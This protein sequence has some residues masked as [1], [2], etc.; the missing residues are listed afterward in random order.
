MENDDLKLS[1]K[2]QVSD[3]IAGIWGQISSINALLTQ[4]ADLKYNVEYAKQLLNE[5]NDKLRVIVGDLE[6][7]VDIVD[8]KEIKSPALVDDMSI[9]LVKVDD[10]DVADAIEESK[11]KKVIDHNPIQFQ[12]L[13]NNID[14]IKSATTTAVSTNSDACLS[15]DAGMGEAL[16]E[17]ASKVEPRVLSLDDKESSAAYSNFNALKQKLQTIIDS[18]YTLGEGGVVSLQDFTKNGKVITTLEFISDDLNKAPIDLLSTEDW[19]KV[20]NY[21]GAIE[22]DNE[23]IDRLVATIEKNK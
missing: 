7:V 9:D 14:S 3:A 11:K 8:G 16:V 5:D 23:L 15:A 18:K 20:A 21:S 17:D 13:P 1:I 22:N 4:L 10:L 2:N 6:N 19:I 12:P